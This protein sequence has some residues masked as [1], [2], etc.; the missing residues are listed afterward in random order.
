MKHYLITAA[1][2][3]VTI[4]IVWRVQALRQVVIGA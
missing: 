2:A 4:A 3:A 1:V